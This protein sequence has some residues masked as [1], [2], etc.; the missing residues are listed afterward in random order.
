MIELVDGLVAEKGL[1]YT[2]GRGAPFSLD[3]QKTDIQFC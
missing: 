3:L 2:N 1:L